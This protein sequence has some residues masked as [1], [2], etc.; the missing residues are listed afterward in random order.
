M[1]KQSSLYEVIRVRPSS[2]RIDVLLRRGRDTRGISLS[3]SHSLHKPQ[4]KGH[5][6]VEQEGGRLQAR[7]SP[8]QEPN[9]PA[10]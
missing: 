7:K 1:R 4:R 8:H 6:S 9:L 10:P 3:L 5:V 2:N